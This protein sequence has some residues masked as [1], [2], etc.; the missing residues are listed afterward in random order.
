M[1]FELKRISDDKRQELAKVMTDFENSRQAIFTGII[2]T[3]SKAMKIYPT[4]NL[5][6]KS[7]MADFSVWGYAVAEALGIGGDNFLKIYRQNS[8]KINDA[9]IEENPI[10]TTILELMNNEEKIDCTPTELFERLNIIAETMRINTN[11]K[12]WAK[13]PSDLSKKINHI[14]SNLL[15]AG[16]KFNT[17]RLGGN[18]GRQRRMTLEVIRNVPSPASLCS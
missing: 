12:C 3:L 1:I 8:E 7:R 13:Q 2:D 18:K 11:S 6:H 4:L 14:K 16:I 10:A 15:D 9:A 17:Y 5:P